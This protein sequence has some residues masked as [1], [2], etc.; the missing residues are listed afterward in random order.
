MLAYT[1]S[2][3]AP[4]RTHTRTHTHTHI[5]TLVLVY[6]GLC[7]HSIRTEPH[8]FEWYGM[9]TTTTPDQPPDP[10]VTR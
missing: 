8:M 5:P 4:T 10:L 9:D 3:C 6:T 1:L 7:E 2:T